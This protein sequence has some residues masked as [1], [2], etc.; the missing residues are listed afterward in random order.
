MPGTPRNGYAL[1]TGSTGGVGRA[2]VALAAAAG[3]R[4]AL[5][6]LEDDLLAV[7]AAELEAEGHVVA[8][9]VA[10]F[11]DPAARD[12]LAA[13]IEGLDA[14]VEI[15]VANAGIGRQGPLHTVPEA[16]I[17]ATLAVNVAAPTWLLHLVLPGMVARGRGR[18]LLVG[19]YTGLFPLPRMAVYAAGKAYLLSLGTAVREELRGTGV[20]VTVLCP[21]LLHTGF[22]NSAGLDQMRLW[23]LGQSLWR[24]AKPAARRGWAAMMAGRAVCLPRPEDRITVAISRILPRGLWLRLTG[25]LLSTDR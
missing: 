25:W 16:A 24:S 18:V 9:L 4:L 21:G 6:A 14:P 23:R 3:C 8:T 10:D 15:V 20:T 7:Q 12:R 19:S 17:D 13:W 2:F 5:V 1:I 11:C 22:E